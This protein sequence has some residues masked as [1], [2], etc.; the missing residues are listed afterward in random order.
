MFRTVRKLPT[1]M[2][3]TTFGRDRILKSLEPTVELARCAFGEV[4]LEPCRQD[5]AS[6][7]TRLPQ[8]IRYMPS[9]H[10]RIECSKIR[11]QAGPCY[12]SKPTTTLK[13]IAVP[14]KASAACVQAGS[15][16]TRW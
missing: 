9:C 8:P 2:Q 12:L 14:K 6:F 5:G 10:R 4:E 7:R 1:Y 13:A 11:G 3:R 16:R 15:L